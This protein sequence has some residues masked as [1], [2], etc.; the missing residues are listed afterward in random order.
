MY[1]YFID[2]AA[3]A[4]LDSVGGAY[5]AYFTTLGD[6]AKGRLWANRFYRDYRAAVEALEAN[7]YRHRVCDLYPFDAIETEYRSFRV[8]WFTIFYSVDEDKKAFAVWHVR[9]SQ[10]DFTK[11]RKR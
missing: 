1:R 5:I 4:E 6:P 7:P 3:Q 11:L 10:S 2:E 9:S 8:G